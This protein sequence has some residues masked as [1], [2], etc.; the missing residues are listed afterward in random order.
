MTLIYSVTLLVVNN[1]LMNVGV[2]SV[3]FILWLTHRTLIRIQ[4][5]IP[6][7]PLI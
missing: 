1:W 3:Y 7:E 6:D 5:F 2:Y 4:Y